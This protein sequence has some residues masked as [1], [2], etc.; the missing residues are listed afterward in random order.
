M[1]IFAMTLVSTH[2]NDQIKIRVSRA[3]ENQLQVNLVKVAKI[4]EK[5]GFDIKL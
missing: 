5:L 4:S 2:S 1:I 3:V